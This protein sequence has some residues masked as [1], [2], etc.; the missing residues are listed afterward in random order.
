MEC[1]KQTCYKRVSGKLSSI[2]SRSKYYWSLL[3]RMLNDKKVP[4]IPPLF[5]HNNFIS[6]FK[7]KT[8]LFN[9][10]FSE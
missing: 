7:E 2:K 4:V 5:H 9:E 1:S 6:N 8:E 10:H 3:E